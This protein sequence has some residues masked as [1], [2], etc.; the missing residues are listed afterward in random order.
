[1]LSY[2]GF[3]LSMT[4]R[5]VSEAA[6]LAGGLVLQVIFCYLFIP[7]YGIEG[8]ALATLLSVVTV[9]VA[10]VLWIWRQMRVTPVTLAVLP[11]IV[12]ALVLAAG[13]WWALGRLLPRDVLGTMVTGAGFLTL[14]SAVGFFLLLT[15]AERHIVYSAFPQY[16]SAT[17]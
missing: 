15:K 14:Y 13:Q 17:E 2:S 12:L 5:H 9:N 10:R 3:A 16:R 11:P 1:V 6:V 7:S 4:G 8:A